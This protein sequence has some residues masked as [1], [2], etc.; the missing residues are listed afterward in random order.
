MLCSSGSLKNLMS[1]LSVIEIPDFLKY[2]VSVEHNEKTRQQLLYYSCVVMGQSV[3]KVMKGQN[4]M[5]RD[6]LGYFVKACR[7]VRGIST[8]SLE[9]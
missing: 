8:V 6:A 5:R 1:K 3:V 7:L 2:F 9:V 4:K